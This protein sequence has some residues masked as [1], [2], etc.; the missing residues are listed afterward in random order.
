MTLLYR[1]DPTTKEF[2]GV[3]EE[4]ESN[5]T[6]V[7]DDLVVDAPPSVDVEEV[8]V[9]D[10]VNEEWTIETDLRSKV[11][12]DADG[13]VHVIENIGET[14]A[15]GWELTPTLAFAKNVKMKLLKSKRDQVVFGTFVWDGDEFD[16]NEV[17]QSRILGL[18]T[19]ALNTPGIFP[20]NWRLADNTWRSLSATD[21]EDLFAAMQAHIQTSFENF[22]DHETAIAALTTVEDVE[23]YDITTGW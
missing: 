20:I 11:Y 14:P 12:Y 6:T 21:A 19:S 13:N 17:S 16:G 18:Y 22:A 1:F 9:W 7:R 2:L 15:M 10:T 8:A 23:D 4:D 5:N 3:V